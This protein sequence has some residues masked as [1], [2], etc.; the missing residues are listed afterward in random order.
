MSDRGLDSLLDS[1][2]NDHNLLASAT[3]SP[4]IPPTPSF[5]PDYERMRRLAVEED[6]FARVTDVFF[7]VVRRDYGFGL[8]RARDALIEAHKIYVDTQKQL[9]QRFGDCG[10]FDLA[11][12]HLRNAGLRF[13]IGLSDYNKFVL[14]PR[15]EDEEFSKIFDNAVRN[16]PP[17]YFLQQVMAAYEKGDVVGI[18]RQISLSMKAFSERGFIEIPDIEEMRSGEPLSGRRYESFFRL[19]LYFS[20]LHKKAYGVAVRRK[21]EEAVGCAVGSDGSAVSHDKIIIGILR[22]EAQDL[23]LDYFRKMVPDAKISSAYDSA[24]AFFNGF[25]NPIYDELSACCEDESH[26]LRTLYKPTREGGNT[27]GKI[28]GSERVRVE[29]AAI[30][31]RRFYEKMFEETGIP[32]VVHPFF[33]PLVEIFESR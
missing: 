10:M 15:I 4:S 24:I 14:E 6:D 18:E 9:A 30:V 20:K 13:E 27:R 29:T 23:M 26:P 31:P 32:I 11:E 8:G 7:S 25:L 2:Y 33:N 5:D 12:E 21:V 17:E 16:T 19:R 1:R 3:A 28:V 22:E